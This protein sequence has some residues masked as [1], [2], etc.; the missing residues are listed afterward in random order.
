M[1]DDA[2]L[3]LVDLYPLGERAQMVAPVA[4]FGVAHPF[5]RLSGECAQRLRGERRP[6]LFD[7]GRRA[8]GVDSRLIPD[9]S[10]LGDALLEPWIGKIGDAMLDGFI[11]P[12]QL[13][14]GFGCPLAQL[15]DVFRSALGAFLPA[16]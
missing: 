11:E 1:T 10:Q 12:H 4:A 14:V 16:V 15:G 7:F 13:G 2:D 6:G 5:S 8:V 3:P 9:G